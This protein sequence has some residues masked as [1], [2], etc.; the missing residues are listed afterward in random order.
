MVQVYEDFNRSLG[1][2]C[3]NVQGLE[4]RRLLGTHS[5]V[6]RLDKHVNGCQCTGFSWGSNL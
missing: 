2:L 3:T 6:A 1:D 4:E 5:G